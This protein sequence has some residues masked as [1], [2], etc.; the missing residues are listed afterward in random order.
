M[1]LGLFSC[2]NNSTSINNIKDN[3]DKFLN[4]FSNITPDNLHIYSPYDSTIE[5]KK[6]NG[7]KIDSIFYKYFSSQGWFINTLPEM[8]AHIFACFKFQYSDSVIGLIIRR[9]SQY[10]ET[11]I[12]L[13][14]WSTNSKKIVYEF[15][16]ADSFGDGMWY[17]VKDAWLTNLNKDGLLDIITRE[18]DWSR[19][20]ESDTDGPVITDS[21]KVYIVQQNCY[22]QVKISIDTPNYKI[23]H[24][25]E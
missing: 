15:E 16:L 2:T 25:E 13:C 5:G 8:Q 23:F 24:W 3:S 14:W 6:F 4:E 1:G 9:E 7:K 20:D 18:K 22:K 19:D 11:A 17:F 10:S 12:D 21:V